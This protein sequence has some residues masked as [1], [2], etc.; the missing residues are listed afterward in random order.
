MFTL[1]KKV[2]LEMFLRQYKYMLDEEEDI[3][4]QFWTVLALLMEELKIKENWTQVMNTLKPEHKLTLL[5]DGIYPLL[6]YPCKEL[7][8]NKNGNQ[9]NS[10]VRFIVASFDSKEKLNG[11]K[12]PHI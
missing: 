2:V 4:S 9:F 6:W 10:L 11:Y 3:S 1:E 8:K 5:I 12:V 7:K